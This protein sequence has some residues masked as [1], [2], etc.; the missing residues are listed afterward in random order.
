MTTV[1]LVD[2]QAE[3]RDG[4]SLLF[5]EFD[6]IEVAGT[7]GDGREAIDRACE[8]LPDVV[9]M[10]LSMPGM[11]GVRATRCIVAT[12]PQTAVVVLTTFADRHRVLAS[13]DAGAVGYLMKD[14]RPDALHDAVL[15]A[16]AGGSPIDPR[17]ART[18]VDL[19]LWGGTRGDPAAGP[20]GQ[21]AAAG[22]ATS[23]GDPAAGTGAPAAAGAASTA[24]HDPNRAD[25]LAELTAKQT[26]VLHLL[27]EGLPNRLM[28]RR[29]GISEKTV[30][31]HLTQIY[32]TLGVTDRV[33]ALL[34]LQRH[35]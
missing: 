30:K 9:L 13:L 15:A 24:P 1:L 16:A 29:L 27:T 17:V 21:S 32:A 23:T 20:A 31:A 10:D 11:D 3:V 28:A 2:D 18:L 7:A 4:L 14:T 19:R 34:W 6:D 12:L 8:L 26:Q 35:Q 5:G 22:S 25:A 33:Q